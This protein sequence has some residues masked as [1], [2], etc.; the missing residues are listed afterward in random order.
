MNLSEPIKSRI[1]GETLSAS[2]VIR[3]YNEEAHIGRLMEGLRVQ[4]V[5]PLEVILVDSGSTDSTV[6][7]AQHYG[8][9]IV[10]KTLPLAVR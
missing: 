9:R 5:Q 8:A 3:A 6:T 1:D 10:R 4:R 2:I 7:I